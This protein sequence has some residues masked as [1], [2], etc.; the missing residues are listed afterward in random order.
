MSLLLAHEFIESTIGAHG[1]PLDVATDPANAYKFT[2]TPVTDFAAKKLAADQAEYFRRYDTDK[3][4]P[5]NRGEVLWSVHLS[6]D[7]E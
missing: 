6:P 2:T 7:T 3:E 1:F 4:H 5:M